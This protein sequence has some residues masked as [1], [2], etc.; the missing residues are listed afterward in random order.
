MKQLLIF[1]FYSV[2]YYG[3]FVPSAIMLRLGKGN[4]APS[5]VRSSK[6]VCLMANLEVSYKATPI[7]AFVETLMVFCVNKLN[8]QQAVYRAPSKKIYTIF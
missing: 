3:L 4:H 8:V 1:S 6:R 2:I 5:M 7:L